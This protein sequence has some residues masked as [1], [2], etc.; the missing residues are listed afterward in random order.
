MAADV[1]ARKR[2]LF[3]SV[4]VMDVAQLPPPKRR[5]VAGRTHVKRVSGMVNTKQDSFTSL[6]IVRC[7]LKYTGFVNSPG[8]GEAG[9]P[10]L[11]T[12][13][14]T[15]WSPILF[16]LIQEDLLKTRA[17]RLMARFACNPHRL[18]VEHQPFGNF[19]FKSTTRCRK[20]NTCCPF[21]HIF[22]GRPVCQASWVDGLD[23]SRLRQ[24]ILEAGLRRYDAAIPGDD[25]PYAERIVNG[26]LR[27][28]QA[29]FAANDQVKAER[30]RVGIPPPEEWVGATFQIREGASYP[31][32][33]V[34]DTR[35]TLSGRVKKLLL[36]DTRAGPER[37]FWGRLRPRRRGWSLRV[38][39]RTPLP[40]GSNNRAWLAALWDRDDDVRIPIFPS[41]VVHY[42]GTYNR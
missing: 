11:I 15:G 33:E 31:T 1:P 3:E 13:F 5:N 21:R 14:L 8:G 36:R 9:V 6:A 39:Y 41:L 25:V 16:N 30:E 32:Y 34:E 42:S 35:V 7:V 28:L 20:T 12:S 27:P 10:M 24:I 40:I 38:P 19:I 23:K 29:L 37:C 22:N 17:L 4:R 2:S 26:Y 18:L